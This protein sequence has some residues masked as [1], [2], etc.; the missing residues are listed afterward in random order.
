MLTLEF[1]GIERGVYS[2]FVGSGRTIQFF[3]GLLMIDFRKRVSWEFFEIERAVY[4]F[5][6]DG[7]GTPGFDL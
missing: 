1:L 7:S 4:S 2:I 6:M 5:T 3:D